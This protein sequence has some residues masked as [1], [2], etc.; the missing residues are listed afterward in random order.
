M[1]ELMRIG[2]LGSGSWATALAKILCENVEALNWWVRTEDTLQHIEK[3]GSNPK[4]IQSIQLPTDKL[5]LSSNMRDV[6]SASDVVI[7]AIPSMYID[8]AF[9]EAFGKEVPVEM[10]NKLFFFLVEYHLQK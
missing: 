3:F 5:K 1:S 4:Y 7:I 8:K 2:L 9:D 10:N 6:I